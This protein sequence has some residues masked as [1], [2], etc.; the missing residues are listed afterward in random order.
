MRATSNGSLCAPNSFLIL[1]RLYDTLLDR[2]GQWEKRSHKWVVNLLDFR[3]IK[4]RSFF[5]ERLTVAYDIASALEYLHDRN[6]IYRDLKPDNIGFD[7]RGDAKLFDFGL[8]TEFDASKV[9]GSYRLTG[10][11]GTMRYMAP[12]VAL[13]QGYTEKADVYSFGIVLWQVV[14]LETPHGEVSDDAIYRKVIH[15]GARPKI[16]GKWPSILRRLLQDCFASAPRRP[17]M[18]K[19]CEILRKTIQ[20]V[21]GKKLVDDDI[22]DSARSVMSLRDLD[23][24]SV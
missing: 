10:N 2:L 21:G 7:V 23:V 16:D 13:S 20:D 17:Q 6:V 19:A 5:A 9:M 4:E 22:V 15:C 14:A 8:A 18:V 1:D 11:T 24:N 12:E 3:K